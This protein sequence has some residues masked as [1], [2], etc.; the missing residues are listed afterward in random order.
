[1]VANF[2]VERGLEKGMQEIG[3][4]YIKSSLCIWVLSQYKVYNMI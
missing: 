1:M 2:Y 3:W 4:H